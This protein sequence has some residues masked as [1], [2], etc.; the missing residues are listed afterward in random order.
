MAWNLQD[1]LSDPSR[2]DALAEKIAGI[3]P[4]IA[5]F[6]EGAVEGQRIVPSAMKLL[7]AHVGRVYA[8]DYLDIDA[9][10]DRHR[11]VAVAKP[12]FGEPDVLTTYGRNSFFFMNGKHPLKVA[13]LHGFDRDQ[14]DVELS[15]EA[16]VRQV[17]HALFRLAL[18]A[19]SQAIVVGD[20]NSMYADS[21][22]AMMLR[23]ASPLFNLLPSKNPGETQSRLERIGSV[24]QRLGQMAIGGPLELLREAGFSD[25]NFHRQATMQVGPLGVQLDHILGRRVELFGHERID[26]EGLSDH[27]G[28]MT[29]ANMFVRKKG[30][31]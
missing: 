18:S 26:P 15:D 31:S 4:D 29:K 3:N 12:S 14:R 11:L 24:S 2:A 6:S 20:L 9:R 8:T 1:G 17:R 19:D 27:F 13:G 30:R 7:Q 22:R 25:S 21:L 5:V 28:I 23:S 16:R 10:A